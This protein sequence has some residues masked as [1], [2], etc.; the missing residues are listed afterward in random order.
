MNKIASSKQSE[1]KEIVA[2][3]DSADISRRHQRFPS[4]ETSIGAGREISAVFT[5][6]NKGNSA[7][8]LS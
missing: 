5:Q 4:G 1:N 3:E 8:K 7:F 2:D 6:A